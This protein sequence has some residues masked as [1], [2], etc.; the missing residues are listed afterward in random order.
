M[1]LD[2]SCRTTWRAHWTNGVVGKQHEQVNQLESI[3][4]VLPVTSHPA[5]KLQHRHWTQ[6]RAEGHDN[7]INA[8]LHLLKRCWVRFL[9]F[10]CR[11]RQHH[12]RITNTCV[13]IWY[14][15]VV[16]VCSVITVERVSSCVWAHCWVDVR[17]GVRCRRLGR[18]QTRETPPTSQMRSPMSIWLVLCPGLRIANKAMHYL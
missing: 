7:H 3:A 1:H 18:F 4:Q 9:S 2:K 13:G 10:P 17:L 14:S 8:S 16:Y 11:D 12:M 15:S 6:P 5:S